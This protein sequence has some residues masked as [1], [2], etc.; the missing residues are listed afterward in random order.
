MDALIH[1]LHSLPNW[2]TF[3]LTCLVLTG[4][5]MIMPLLRRQ[6]TPIRPDKPTTDAAMDG[7]KAVTTFLVFI[8]AVS[9]NSV[10]GQ[11]RQVEEIVQREATLVG[12]I[13]RGLLRTGPEELRAL[14]PVLNDYIRTVITEEWPLMA[15]GGRSA[16]AYDLFNEL[17]RT[18]R[19][20]EV[21]GGRQQAVYGELLR[22]L[23]DLSDARE[24]RLMASRLALPDL[25]WWT[26]MGAILLVLP[27]CA[28]T[29][30]T[31]NSA[32]LKLALAGSLAMLL[33]LVIVID[34]PYSGETRVAPLPFERA[35]ERN[36]SRI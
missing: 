24:Q 10:M 28:M 25:F 8:L 21:E 4:S 26:I 6:L 35:L 2:A 12:Q 36:L 13:D 32:V 7:V 31:L 11:H 9:L 16:R 30:G 3:A 1:H 18:I 15:E 14:R 27:L 22:A 20:T 33:A 34:R 19:R 29:A 5:F 23:S 17:S